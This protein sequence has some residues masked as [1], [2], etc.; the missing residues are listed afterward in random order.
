VFVVL[1]RESNPTLL[2]PNNNMG[3][4]ASNPVAQAA[5]KNK[6]NEAANNAKDGATVAMGGR[7]EVQKTQDQ[8]AKDRNAEYEQKKQDREERKKKL[9]GQ[10][11]D[12]KQANS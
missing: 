7:T 5:A 6:M 2:F 4:G 1:N 12:H 11:A 3:V 8:R 9:A 10:R